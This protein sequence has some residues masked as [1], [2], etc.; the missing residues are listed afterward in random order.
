MVKVICFFEPGSSD[1]FFF[2]MFIVKLVDT[3]VIR[4]AYFSWE[5][6][7]PIFQ[8]GKYIMRSWHCEK[9]QHVAVCSNIKNVLRFKFEKLCF[10][11]FSKIHPCRSVG[12]YLPWRDSI[13]RSV[14]S[15]SLLGD[16]QRRYHYIFR[17]GLP[18]L[19][20]YNIP[21]RGK[22]KITVKY[23]KWPQ[24]IPNGHKIYQMAVK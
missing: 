4:S 21:K 7:K 18:D 6:R 23:T 13:S 12:M 16:R 8:F 5:R 17:P 14:C 3:N 22:N 10:N 9:S 1:M 11:F 15:S 24:N 19:S 2:K 20:W